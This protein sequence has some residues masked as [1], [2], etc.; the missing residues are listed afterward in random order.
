MNLEMTIL[1]LITFSGEA[2]SDA[3]EAIGHAKS[4]AMEAAQAAIEKAS[5]NLSKA[6]KSQTD[7]IQSEAK[8]NSVEVSIL[9]IH[10]QDHL[11]NAI[12][13]RDL[14]KEMVDMYSLIH[15]K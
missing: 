5:E 1:N 14:A 3:M 8:G 2:K 12:T 7:L 13:I 15:S 6:H 9:L 11:M 10:A 4:G